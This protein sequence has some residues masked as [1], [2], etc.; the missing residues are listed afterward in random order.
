M[1]TIICIYII[2]LIFQSIDL[3]IWI[4]IFFFFAR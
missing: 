2:N 1:K 3:F 4:S